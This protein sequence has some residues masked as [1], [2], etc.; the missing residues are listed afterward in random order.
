MVKLQNATANTTKNHHVKITNEGEIY[1]INKT[2]KKMETIQNQEGNSYDDEL[3]YQDEH[4]KTATV[5]KTRK[6]I[7]GSSAMKTS[8]AE[9]QQWLQDIPLQNSF[10]S[11]IEEIDTD[12]KEKV[13]THIVKSPPIYIDAQIIDPLIKYTLTIETSTLLVAKVSQ[14][15]SN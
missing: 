6:I 5:H 8:H 11:L 15:T 4:W 2:I 9:K 7:P 10:G 14:S 12:P 3:S 13:T 1:Y